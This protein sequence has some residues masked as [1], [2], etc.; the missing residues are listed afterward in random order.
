MMKMIKLKIH[1]YSSIFNHELIS[2]LENHHWAH[3]I[4]EQQQVNDAERL[5]FNGM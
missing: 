3:R 4:A 1:K 5:A 2:L